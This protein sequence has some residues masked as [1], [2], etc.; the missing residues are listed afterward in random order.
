MSMVWP[1]MAR[2]LP[3]AKPEAIRRKMLSEVVHEKL[4]AGHYSRRTE[5]AYLGWIRRFIRFHGGRHPRELGAVEVQ[6]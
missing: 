6:A 2:M 4:R 3:A 1:I 5:A